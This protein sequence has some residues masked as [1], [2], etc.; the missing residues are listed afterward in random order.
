MNKSYRKGY[1]FQRRVK[2]Y[3][4]KKGFE[5]IV[6]PRSQFP[7]ITAYKKLEVGVDTTLTYNETE[8]VSTIVKPFLVIDVECKVNKYL[9]KKEKKEAE[10]RLEAG[11]CNA[12]FV[13]YRDKRQIKFYGKVKNEPARWGEEPPSYTG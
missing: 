3:L 4:E 8:R 7:D 13:A 12:F 5:V 10:K 1:N 11:K 6:R 9:N 2:K